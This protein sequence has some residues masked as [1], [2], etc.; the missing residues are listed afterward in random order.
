VF[1]LKTFFSGEVRSEKFRI[2]KANN[3][4]LISEDYKIKLD[5]PRGLMYQKKSI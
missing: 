3:P 2:T 5:D 4:D 1:H